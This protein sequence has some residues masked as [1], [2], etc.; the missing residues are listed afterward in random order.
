MKKKGSQKAKGRTSG[1]GICGFFALLFEANELAS[2]KRKLT[3]EQIEKEVRKEF[4]NRKGYFFK[5]ARPVNNRPGGS[6]PSWGKISVNTYRQKYNKGVFTRKV[7]PERYSFRYDK[8][9]L[10]VDTTTG[11][12]FL[13]PEEIKAINLR[14]QQFRKERMQE[15][16]Y[17]G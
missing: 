6:S 1:L 8:Q 9:G 2:K 7:P 17:G 12:R 10:V 13:L 15:L 11:K 4:P 14:H 5:G 3:N 16:V